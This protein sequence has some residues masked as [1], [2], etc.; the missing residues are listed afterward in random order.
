[1]FV[2]KCVICDRKKSTIASDNIIQA[3]CLGDFFKNLAE[4]GLNISKK[5]AKNVLSNRGRGFRF[6]SK[7]S[8]SI[9]S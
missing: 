1:M 9:R 3:E 4:I 7:N 6:D 2:G 8:Y 5:M